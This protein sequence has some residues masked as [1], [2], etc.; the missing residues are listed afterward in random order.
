MPN[1]HSNSGVRSTFA[2]LLST[3]RGHAPLHK[4]NSDYP[5]VKPGMINDNCSICLDDYVVG[6]AV[7]RLNS[8]KHVFHENCMLK[9]LGVP[10]EYL[11]PAQSLRSLNVNRSAASCSGFFRRFFD[12][13]MIIN[14][15]ESTLSDR[16]IALLHQPE[17]PL[18]L[19]DHIDRINRY[20]S[21]AFGGEWYGYQGGRPNCPNCRSPFN[22]AGGYTLF[23]ITR[24]QSDPPVFATNV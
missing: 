4:G 3:A 23:R 13:F 19:A 1:E 16:D 15:S 24:Y 17:N 14:P 8:C 20:R 12:S 7:A 9:Y 22:F 5:E 6:E 11:D 21:Y 10:D 2:G 18:F